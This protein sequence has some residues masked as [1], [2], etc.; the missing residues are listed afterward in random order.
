VPQS[1]CGRSLAGPARNQMLSASA[2]GIVSGHAELDSFGPKNVLWRLRHNSEGLRAAI[3][4]ERQH[5][6]IF[7]ARS[8]GLVG[9]RTCHPLFKRQADDGKLTR[10]EAMM[11][12]PQRCR[13][14]SCEFTG[15]PASIACRRRHE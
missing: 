5:G 11:D 14:R 9:A 6:G 15:R 13:Y 2:K 1:P 8:G 10:G 12:D 3:T 7:V 4:V